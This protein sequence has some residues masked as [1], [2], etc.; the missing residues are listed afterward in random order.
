MVIQELDITRRATNTSS[1]RSVIYAS[2]TEFGKLLCDRGDV[3]IQNVLRKSL[4]FTR[5]T[6]WIPYGLSSNVC[7]FLPACIIRVFW[8]MCSLPYPAR[9]GTKQYDP[10]VGNVEVQ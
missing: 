7:E 10:E 5:S 4:S 9:P 6:T 8:Q 2:L 1:F 3:P